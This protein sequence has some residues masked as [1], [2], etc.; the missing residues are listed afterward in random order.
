MCTAY[1]TR[2]M[3]ST[4]SPGRAS[5]KQK[6]ES[7]TKTDADVASIAKRVQNLFSNS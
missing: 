2:S 7:F 3:T 1:E 6:G 4:P 5:P